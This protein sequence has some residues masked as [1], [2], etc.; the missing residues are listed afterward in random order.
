MESA[1]ML[2]VVDLARDFRSQGVQCVVGRRTVS[3]SQL[4][5]LVRFTVLLTQMGVNVLDMG[6]ARL[7]TGTL[8]SV[9]A[10]GLAGALYVLPFDSEYPV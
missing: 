8:M 7:G 2:K 3:F 10:G 4:D 1:D 5:E 6:R 9:A